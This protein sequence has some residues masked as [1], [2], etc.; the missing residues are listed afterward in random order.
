MDK[1]ILYGGAAALGAYFWWASRSSSTA[2][3]PTVT[4]TTSTT[5]NGVG[6][7]ISSALAAVAGGMRNL[8]AT[9]APDATATNPAT[10]VQITT[11]PAP[12]TTSGFVI[13]GGGG[14]SNPA[15]RDSGYTNGMGIAINDPAAVGRLNSINAFVNTL[16]WSPANKA[17]SVEAMR[18]A[19]AQYGVSNNELAIAAHYNVSDINALMGA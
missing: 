17:A 5:P 6:F 2:A 19:Q 4:R 12:A 14:A 18:Q 15:P 16:D 3:A 1:R 10:P 13:G 8:P 9:N 7:D 11:G